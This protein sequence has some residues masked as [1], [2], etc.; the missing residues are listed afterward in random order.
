[1]WAYLQIYIIDI[2]ITFVQ[3]H[4]F[5]VLKQLL[6]SVTVNASKLGE[7]K[8]RSKLKAT[9]ELCAE[10]HCRIFDTTYIY[11]RKTFKGHMKWT[12]IFKK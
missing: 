2:G 9:N 10:I 4:R 6:V 11:C 1:M 5:I 12:T 7:Q 8:I 3:T